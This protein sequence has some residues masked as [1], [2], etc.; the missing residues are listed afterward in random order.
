MIQYKCAK[1]DITDNTCGWTDH[2]HFGCGCGSQIHAVL[3]ADK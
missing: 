1:P 2:K 3:I